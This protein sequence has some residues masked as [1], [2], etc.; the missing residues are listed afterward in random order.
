MNMLYCKDKNILIK[1][2][3]D[4]RHSLLQAAGGE[5]ERGYTFTVLVA[6][7]EGKILDPGSFLQ[8]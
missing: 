1:T 8:I 5:R 2:N 7:S 4:L 3:T 6:K